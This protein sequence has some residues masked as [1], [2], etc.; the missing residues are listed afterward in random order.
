MKLLSLHV[1][2]LKKALFAAAGLGATGVILIRSCSTA[3]GE[4]AHPHVLESL[5]V[6]HEAK[7][8]EVRGPVLNFQT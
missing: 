8:H 3:G 4:P 1:G 2:A 6:E 7:R 5:S